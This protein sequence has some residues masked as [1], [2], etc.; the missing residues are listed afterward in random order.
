[1]SILH[2]RMCVHLRKKAVASET[3][4]LYSVV[5]AFLRRW[6]KPFYLPV[7]CDEYEGLLA[8]ISPHL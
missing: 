1:M 6:I 3:S 4:R 7:I 2:M 8:F 5:C